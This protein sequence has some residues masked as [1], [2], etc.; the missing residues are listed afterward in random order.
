MSEVAAKETHARP[1]AGARGLFLAQ[2]IKRLYRIAAMLMAARLLGVEGFGIYALL[3]TIMEMAALISGSG[4]GD[5]LTRET[6]KSPA[7]ARGIAI[8]VTQI[9]LL[10]IV[11]AAGILLGFLQLLSSSAVVLNAALLSAALIPRALSESAQG[12]LRG[13]QSFVLLPWLEFFQGLVLLAAIPLFL[14]SGYGVRGIIAAEII[15]WVGAA[16]VAVLAVLKNTVASMEAP[17]FRGVM[18]SILPFNVYPFIANIYDRADVV[19]LS[20]L[21]GAFATGIYALPYRAFSSL[22]IIPYGI[23]GALLPGFSASAA[24]ATSRQSCSRVMKFLYV[25]SLLL[26]LITAA[27]ARPAVA[28]ILGQHFA[29]SATALKILI[30]A[31]IPAFLNH[32]L[33]TLLLA[34]HREKVFLWTASICTI[35]N[36]GANVL[37]IPRFSWVAA[38]AVTILTEMLLLLQ[39]CFLMQKYFGHQVL[40]QH[41][42]R[43]TIVFAAAFALLI[44]LSRVVPEVWAGCLVCSGFA[45]FAW[46]TVQDVSEFHAM[47]GRSR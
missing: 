3:L 40:P 22:Q 44:A 9:R 12:V 13:L 6:A 17:A 36:C 20:R 25:V 46:F 34:A 27:C 21:A 5:Y 28:L 18:S 37:L 24:D 16:V 41:W 15:S 11:A 1:G 7:R 33:N 14:L 39:N 47:A 31:A 4:Y 29:M 19:I 8:R 30:W 23:M 42:P 43:I 32:A 38:A 2:I 45:L 26:V 35:F 10:Y